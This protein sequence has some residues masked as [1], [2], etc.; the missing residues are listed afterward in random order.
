MCNADTPYLATEGIVAPEKQINPFTNKP[1]KKENKNDW[2]K[3][4]VASS[5]STR[6]RNKSGWNVQ[7]EEW[8]TV[9]DD[10]YVTENWSPL[11]KD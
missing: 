11:F 3:I 6:I 7:D 5:Q 8:F 4:D 2:I 1:L 9:H 10:I